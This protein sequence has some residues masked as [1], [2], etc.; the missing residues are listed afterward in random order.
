MI[1]YN[2]IQLA[3]FRRIQCAFA[4]KL[5]SMCTDLKEAEADCKQSMDVHVQRILESKRTVLFKQLLEEISYP[6]AKV[7]TEMGQGF[8]LCGWL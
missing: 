5:V 1:W 3:E 7:A 6:D 4:K 8:P 2:M